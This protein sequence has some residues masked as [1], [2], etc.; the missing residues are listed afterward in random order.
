MIDPIKTFKMSNTVYEG[1]QDM[2]PEEK[3]TFLEV[4]CRIA[5]V[6]LNKNQ[7]EKIWRAYDL[8]LKKGGDMNLRDSMRIIDEVDAPKKVDDLK[9]KDKDGN[10]VPLTSGV[11]DI[12]M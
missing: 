7:I 2:T 6:S 1:T 9:Y 10:Y 11:T 3:T 4:F 12:S 5:K 8:M